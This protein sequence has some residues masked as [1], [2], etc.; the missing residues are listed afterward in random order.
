MAYFGE[1]SK[2]ICREHVFCIC[3]VE[4]SINVNCVTFYDEVFLCFL[5]HILYIQGDL[6]NLVGKNNSNFP[7]CYYEQ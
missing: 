3:R 2:S 7:D 6:S 4:Y 5:L 1:C